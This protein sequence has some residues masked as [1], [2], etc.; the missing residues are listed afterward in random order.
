MSSNSETSSLSDISSTRD[1]LSEYKG[2]EDVDVVC[3]RN[4]WCE[5]KPSAEVDSDQIWRLRINCVSY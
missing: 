4:S 3:S 2:D 1:D 5:D